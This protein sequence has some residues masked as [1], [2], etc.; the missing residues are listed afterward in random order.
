V[1]LACAGLVAVGRRRRVVRGWLARYQGGY[2]QL[3]ATDGGPRAVRW[4]T[5]AEVT[6]TFRTTTVYT[7][8]AA[9]T[10]TRLHRFSASPC[11]TGGLAPVV[12]PRWGS[13]RLLKDAVRVVGP[14]L[15][16]AAE[17]AY[18]AGQPAAFGPV[19][20][21]RDGVTVPGAATPVSWPDIRSIRLR[22]VD[23]ARGGRVVRAVH[24]SCR[25]RPAH[26]VIEVSGLPNGIFLARVIA[27][28]AAGH[29]VP[30]KGKVS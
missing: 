2:A 14:R 3:L 15:V 24:L 18:D 26:R 22:H 21:S 25:S 30:V 8:Q 11:V 29:G 19:R 4:T 1:L 27:H 7:S 10:S 6:V 20:V 12:G 23:L 16:S 17:D 9:Y 28:A 5:V 13:W